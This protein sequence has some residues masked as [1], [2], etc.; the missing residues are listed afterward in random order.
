MKEAGLFLKQSF[1]IYNTYKIM[2][3]FKT[4]LCIWDPS[5]GAQLRRWWPR[6]EYF[7][8]LPLDGGDTNTSPRLDVA[9]EY[10]TIAWA[11]P[12]TT[13]TTTTTTTAATTS[14]H[15]LV[16]GGRA[17]PP[18]WAK[19]EREESHTPH[20]RLSWHLGTFLVLHSL[21]LFSLTIFPVFPHYKHTIK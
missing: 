15:L 20:N 13:F 10:S 1:L 17:F 19:T 7:D 5:S 11:S 16:P 4:D 14:T 9:V 8:D 6:S 18:Y 2:F 21:F 3:F 12:T